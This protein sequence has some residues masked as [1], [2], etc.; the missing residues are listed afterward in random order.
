MVVLGPVL[1]GLRPERGAGVAVVLPHAL[2]GG[3]GL[4]EAEQVLGEG[5]LLDPVAPRVLAVGGQLVD[6]GLPVALAMGPE[7]EV[8]VEHAGE[9]R[10][11]L[12]RTSGS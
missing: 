12:G 10:T 9:D 1:G 6:R 11:V 7:V 8:V 4:H 5:D 3:V 2:E